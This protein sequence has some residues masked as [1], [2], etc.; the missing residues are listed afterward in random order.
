VHQTITKYF[1]IRLHGDTFTHK[2]FTINRLQAKKH[3]VKAEK[4]KL[5]ECAL[6]AREKAAERLR[7]RR[8]RLSENGLLFTESAQ[9]WQ[10][11]PPVSPPPSYFQSLAY[12]NNFT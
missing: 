2:S 8:R 10:E 12:A 9:L 3:A 7:R 11:S 6:R 4:R 5:A 1:N